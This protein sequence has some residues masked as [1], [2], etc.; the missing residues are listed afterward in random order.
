[1][2]KHLK[3]SAT[4]TA[5]LLST[6]TAWLIA[7]TPVAC[8]TAAPVVPPSAPAPA[9]TPTPTPAPAI[10]TATP[11]AELQEHRS[12]TFATTA[13]AVTFD[14]QFPCARVNRC[15]EIAPHDYR[16]TITPEN[17]PINPSPWYAFRVRADAPTDITVRFVI[18]TKTARPRPR[19]ST[20]GTHWTRAT[21]AQWTGAS[22][23]PEC[24][25]R[26]HAEPAATWVASNDI[27]GNDRLAA[28]S[29]AL[30]VR[31]GATVETFGT[32]AGG[33]ALRMFTLSA[34][35][36]TPEDW[37]IVIGRQH[38]PE[39]SGSVG[40]MAFMDEIT[41]ESARARAF[42]GAFRVALVPVVNPDGVHEGQWRSTLGGVDS[43]RD[44]GAFTQPE[45]VALR[46]AILAIR[47]RPGA[48][49]WLAIDFHGTNKDI[50][51]TPLA[52]DRTFPPRFASQWV[53]AI[54]ARFPDYEVESTSAHNATEWTF[55]RWA[56]ETLGAPGITYE[57]GSSTPHAQIQ[58][59]VTGAAD[60][61]MR[62]LMDAKTA[63]AHT[64][65]DA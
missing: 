44:W 58:K 19:L 26:M 31:T 10:T 33:R 54:Q 3:Y 50:L 38:P 62:L 20:D 32:S 2:F 7:L 6:L 17:D 60:E 5:A 51:Y 39:V 42:R 65:P 1:M 35:A 56:Y 23:A 16:I 12:W 55:K 9:L 30:A 63:N 13:P 15:E 61:A 59:I 45:T 36:N 53:A 47:S 21:D 25:L 29:D 43:N 57:L 37:V 34:N 49:V 24:V 41:S 28:W 46:D 18:A 48:R 52:D 4:P 27:I 64:P 11:R 22:G 14:N 40:L 8:Q